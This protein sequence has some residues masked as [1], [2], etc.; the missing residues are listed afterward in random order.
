MTQTNRRRRKLRRKKKKKNNNSTTT[1]A[2]TRAAAAAATKTTTTRK[3]NATYS[4][5]LKSYS[6][7]IWLTPR[8][9][10]SESYPRDSITLVNEY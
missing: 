6:K 1:T 9:I 7:E 4:I 5:L 8:L 2:T 3:T 10:M